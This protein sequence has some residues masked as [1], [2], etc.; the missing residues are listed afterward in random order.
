MLYCNYETIK[1]TSIRKNA[2]S[3]S[4]CESHRNQPKCY[5]ILGNRATYP[6]R[7][8]NHYPCALFQ[9]NHRLFIRGKGLL[10]NTIPLPYCHTDQAEYNEARGAYLT[11]LFGYTPFVSL[12]RYDI[13]PIGSPPKKHFA[14]KKR[15]VNTLLFYLVSKRNK[16]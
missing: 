2:L 13:L 1:R 9:R 3:I 5:C 10:K 16:L 12:S 11:L 4:A 15:R 6:Q 8:S 14:Y 7:P